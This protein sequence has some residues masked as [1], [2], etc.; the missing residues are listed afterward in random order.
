MARTYRN[1]SFSNSRYHGPNRKAI[2]VRVNRVNRRAAKLALE[3][4]VEIDVVRPQ[5]DWIGH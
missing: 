1:D 4:G 3:A 5:V 2:Q